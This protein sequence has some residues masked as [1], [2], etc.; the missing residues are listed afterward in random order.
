MPGW[1]APFLLHHHRGS[2]GLFRDIHCKLE[3]SDSNVHTYVLDRP[4]SR[5]SLDLGYKYPV[6]P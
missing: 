3:M 4:I 5:C 1:V 6:F 2:S